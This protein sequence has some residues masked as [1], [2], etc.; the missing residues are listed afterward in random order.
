MP[1]TKARYFILFI[2]TTQTQYHVTLTNGGGIREAM[3]AAEAVG[4]GR[5]MN[6]RGTKRSEPYA[7]EV[8]IIV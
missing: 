5:V 6:G 2:P 8:P 7:A 3:T 1:T 4:G